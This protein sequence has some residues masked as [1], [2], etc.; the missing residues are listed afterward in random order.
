M[1]YPHIDPQA[2][3]ETLKKLHIDVTSLQSKIPYAF[4]RPG[5]R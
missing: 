4:P 1:I 3:V 5:N 2:N